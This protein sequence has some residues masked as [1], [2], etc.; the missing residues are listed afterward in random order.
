MRVVLVLALGAMAA[1]CGASSHEP[2][3]DDPPVPSPCAEWDDAYWCCDPDNCECTCEGYWLCTDVGDALHCVEQNPDVPHTAMDWECRY[4]T[5]QIVCTTSLEGA[6]PVVDRSWDC[7]SNGDRLECR[8]PIRAEDFPESDGPWECAYEAGAVARVC[9]EVPAPWGTWECHENEDGRSTCRKDGAEQPDDGRWD[10][11]RVDGADYCVSDHMPEGDPVD[12]NCVENG[13]M[14]ECE[15]VP[16]DEPPN[17]GPWEC[18]WGPDFLEC[19][20][21]DPDPPEGCACVEGGRRF[22]DEPTFGNWGEQECTSRNGTTRWDRCNEIA[23]P[24]GCEPGGADAREYE[25]HYRGGFWDGQVFDPNDD[26]VLLMPPDNWFNP[27]AQDCAMRQGSCIQDMW[28]LDVDM[29][30]QESVGSCA[31]IDECG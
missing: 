16:G 27:A 21:V 20:E 1:G 23:I 9:D 19:E 12:W 25:W 30:N 7:T 14:V 22:C 11:Y 8:R 17:G 13:E 26:G 2:G 10:C 5:E 6:G 3:D 24:A 28:D 4:E 15:K 29:D 18:A 31:G